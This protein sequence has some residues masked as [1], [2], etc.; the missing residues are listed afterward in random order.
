MDYDSNNVIFLTYLL[1]IL[2]V[3]LYFFSSVYHPFQILEKIM[4]KYGF[5]P[6]KKKKRKEKKFAFL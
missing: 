4:Y 1:I 2:F 5:S 3:I 6:L